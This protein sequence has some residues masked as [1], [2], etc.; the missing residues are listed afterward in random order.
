M[1][2]RGAE[3]AA[4][5]LDSSRD[6]PE[7]QALELRRRAGLQLMISGRIEA[8]LTELGGVLDAVGMTLPRTPVR[9]LVALLWYRARIRLRGMRFRERHESE[10]S[11]ET[12]HQLRIYRW[13]GNVRELEGIIQRALISSQGEIVELAEP[14]VEQSDNDDTPRIISSTIAELKLVEREHILAVLEATNWKISGPSGA[15]AQ[16]GLP[17]STLRSKMK[18]L[19]IERPH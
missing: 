15:A 11:A 5:F 8:G 18:K 2:G 14:L 4:A 12:M 1:R 7:D 13:P 3:A 19:S 6:A 9:A 16:L 17:P 10:I